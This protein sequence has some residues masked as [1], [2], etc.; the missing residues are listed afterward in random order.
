MLCA[1]CQDKPAEKT[2]IERLN[3]VNPGQPPVTIAV[4]GV[5]YE[6][7][8]KSHGTIAIDTNPRDARIVINGASIPADKGTNFFRTFDGSETVY[9][10]HDQSYW[11]YQG[12]RA[13][14]CVIRP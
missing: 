1:G 8:F 5:I 7:Q 3:E 14:Q 2:F 13:E 11:E 4:G 6:C 10:G 9:F 12:E